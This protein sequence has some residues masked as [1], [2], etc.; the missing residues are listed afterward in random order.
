MVEQ[1]L[2]HGASVSKRTETGQ[3]AFHYTASKNHT[4]VAQA[5]VDHINK[6]ESHG[7]KVLDE[8]LNVKDQNGMLPLHRACTK[9]NIKWVKW[10]FGVVSEKSRSNHFVTLLLDVILLIFRCNVEECG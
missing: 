7:S 10:L 9:G 2:K 1:L 6:D 4:E 3:T 8:V 5:L